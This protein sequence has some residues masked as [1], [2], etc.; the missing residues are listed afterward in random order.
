M[1][2][3]IAGG[4]PKWYHNPAEVGCKEIELSSL[5]LKQYYIERDISDRFANGLGSRD[6]LQHQP[7]EFFLG[8]WSKTEKSNVSQTV[9][10]LLSGFV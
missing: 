2:Q 8:F 1:D 4:L 7:F 3:T 5:P 10:L 9:L 6:A